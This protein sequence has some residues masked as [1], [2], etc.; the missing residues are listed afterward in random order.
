MTEIKNPMYICPYIYVCVYFYI[1]GNLQMYT[2]S[3]KIQKFPQTTKIGIQQF[4]GIYR[5]WCYGV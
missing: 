4:K 2:L 3:I 1:A 5:R